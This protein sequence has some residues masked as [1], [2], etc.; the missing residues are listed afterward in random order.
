[1]TYTTVTLLRN[2]MGSKEACFKQCYSRESV[3]EFY[4]SEVFV[5]NVGREKEYCIQKEKKRDC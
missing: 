1:M 3:V 5:E 4:I 2:L